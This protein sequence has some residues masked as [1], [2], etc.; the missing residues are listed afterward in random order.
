MNQVD[1]VIIPNS[2]VYSNTVVM[3]TTVVTQHLIVFRVL[4]WWWSWFRAWPWPWMFV[5]SGSRAALASAA[6][7]PP[8]ATSGPRATAAPTATTRTGPASAMAAKKKVETLNILNKDTRVATQY[9]FHQNSLTFHWLF[10]DFR[11]FSRP[12]WRPILAIF[13]HWKFCTNIYACWFNL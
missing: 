4:L 1:H 9:S 8:A 10:P 13:I 12:F 3:E 2:L 6:T 5:W 7:T 11:P